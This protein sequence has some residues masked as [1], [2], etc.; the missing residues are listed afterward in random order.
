MLGGGEIEHK[1]KKTH[2]HG[3]WCGDFW[4]EGREGSMRELNGNGKKYNRD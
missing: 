1:G 2:G 3:Q 4:W